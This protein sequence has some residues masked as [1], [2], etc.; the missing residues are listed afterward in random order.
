M[1]VV[2]DRLVGRCKRPSYVKGVDE[3]GGGMPVN[4]VGGEGPTLGWPN[5]GE[6]HLCCEMAGVR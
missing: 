2:C 1:G 3:L 5:R 4:G 6:A